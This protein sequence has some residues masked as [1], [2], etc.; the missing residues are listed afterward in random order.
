MRIDPD[1]LRHFWTWSV[2]FIGIVLLYLSFARDLDLAQR[3]AGGMGLVALFLFAFL[4]EFVDSS[5]GMGYGTTLTPVLLIMGF[6]TMD[7]VPAILFSEFL[8]GVTAGV[9]HHRLGNVDLTRGTRSR[10]VTDI[11][12]ACSVAGTVAAVLLA[13]TLPAAL[14]RGYIG[15]MIVGIGLFILLTSG[16]S[17]RFTWGRI[18]GLGTIAAF[19]KGISGGGYGPLVTGGQVLVGVPEKNAVGITSLAEGM[20]CLV[21]LALY[22]LLEGPLA[23]NLALPLAAGAMCSVPAATLTVK[24]LPEA[25]LRRSIGYATVYLGTLSLIKI[26]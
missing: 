15:V 2:V 21:G 22:L 19:N 26:L 10:R 7:V 1:R 24:V 3:L 9:L 25:M 13:V 23:W 11:L 20:V 18:L 4:A 8:S 16:R 5:L 6:Q 14:V 12:A 17:L